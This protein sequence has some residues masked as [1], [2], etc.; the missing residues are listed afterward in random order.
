[1]FTIVNIQTALFSELN[2]PV[3]S[4]IVEKP[5]ITF[6]IADNTSLSFINIYYIVDVNRESQNVD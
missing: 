1:M 2:L 5:S 3:I 6:A 4:T